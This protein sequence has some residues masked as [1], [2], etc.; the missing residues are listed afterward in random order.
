MRHRLGHTLVS[1]INSGETLPKWVKWVTILIKGSGQEISAHVI[2]GSRFWSRLVQHFNPFSINPNVNRRDLKTRP[3]HERHVLYNSSRTRLW[4]FLSTTKFGQGCL[5]TNFS[6]LDV[7][8][9]KQTFNKNTEAQVSSITIQLYLALQGNNVI[10]K[11]KQ[12]QSSRQ[13][14]ARS[15]T[16][17]PTIPHTHNSK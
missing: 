15:L 16:N 17:I 14:V 4:G 8:N 6:Y 13:H 10:P 1:L 9:S 2:K 7:G 3:T 11:H 12:L 5:F